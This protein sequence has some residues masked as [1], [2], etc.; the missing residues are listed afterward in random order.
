M[1]VVEVMA[2]AVTGIS[3][4]IRG[5]VL[6]LLMLLVLLLH[7]RRGWWA[8]GLGRRGGEE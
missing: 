5:N 8:V 7:N 3:V 2:M 6:L 4:F 1:I